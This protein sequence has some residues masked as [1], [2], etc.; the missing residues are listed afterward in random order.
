MEF[1]Q[2]Y[3]PGLDP[4]LFILELMKFT[5]FLYN[6][7]SVSRKF[8]DI[9][10]KSFNNFIYYLLIP[11]LKQQIRTELSNDID[12]DT[13][14]KIF[15][16]L[17]NSRSP[18][19][20]LLTE[21]QRFAMYENESVYQT[22]KDFKIGV[23]KKK[24]IEVGLTETIRQTV[25]GIHIPLPETLRVFLQI[26]GVFKSMM[27]YQASLL[28][29]KVT[30]SNIIQAK[31]WLTKFLSFVRDRLVFPLIVFFDD[32][33]TRNPLGS[34]SGEQKFGAVYVSLPCLPP[35]LSSKISNISIS[36]IFHTKDRDEYG[37]RACFQPLLQDLK[38]L[39]ETG[40][41]ISIDG[42]L[43]QVYFECVLFVGD[44]LGLNSC[45]G[46]VSNFLVDYCCRICR[47]TAD[48][49]KKLKTECSSLVRDA[50]NYSEDLLNETGGG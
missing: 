2:D 30:V 3:G 6:N 44:N 40:I 50:R 13:M 26:P 16:V 19:S 25:S 29:Q 42:V 32:C 48:Q 22:P 31:L 41:T 4:A 23:S 27:E 8:I 39:S 28:E 15:L 9:I 34:H 47:A 7:A 43:T 18:F 12:P 36:T 17:D 10:I 45:C 35:H 37:N 14:G 46:F 21:K 1:Q 11:Y 49:I 33:E 38:Y 24:E 5:L 20:S